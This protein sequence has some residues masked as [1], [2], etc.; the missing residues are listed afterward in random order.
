M[1]RIKQTAVTLLIIIFALFVISYVIEVIDNK[2]NGEMYSKIDNFIHSLIQINKS[3]ESTFCANQAILRPNKDSKKILQA[4][5]D[6]Q[7]TIKKMGELK[8][9]EKIPVKR[10]KLLIKIKKD[11]INMQQDCYQIIKIQESF[12]IDKSKQE[13]SEI[14]Y[15]NDILRRG[16]YLAPKISD[17]KLRN[18]IKSISKNLTGKIYIKL[19][20]NQFEKSYKN[21]TGKD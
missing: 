14:V 10:K 9:P 12:N 19:T 2:K 5:K 1:K 3:P 18:N 8:I 11:F 7:Y 20:K 17:A 16:Y 6:C 21:I 13:H 4:E 15:S